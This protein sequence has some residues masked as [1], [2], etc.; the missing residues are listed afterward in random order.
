[1]IGVGLSRIYLGVHFPGDVLGGW[2]V[3]IVFL[4]L[5][6]QVEPAAQ[7]RLHTAPWSHQIALSVVAP[8]AL[9]L[10]NANRDSAQLMGVI[11]G[12]M[13]G[14]LIE[15]RWVRFSVKGPLLQR[16]VR[17]GVGG[18]ILLSVWL[19][20]KAIFPS[21]PEAA[22]LVFR[23]IRYGLVGMWASLGA[24]WLFVRMG[25]ALRESEVGE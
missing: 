11:A 9:F 10:L 19:G 2:L 20:S 7:Q 21:G 23:L 14:V 5:Y 16:A 18:G 24:P 3:G 12:M 13:A 15:L 17:F 6:L 1:V 22:G 8:I 25:L 4:A